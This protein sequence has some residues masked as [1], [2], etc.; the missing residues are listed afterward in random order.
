MAE[1]VTRRQ[2]LRRAVGTTAALG[3]LAVEPKLGAQE[4]PNVLFILADDLGYGD[5]S[6]YGRPDYETPALDRLAAQGMRF[7]SAYSAGAVCTP[8]RCALITGRYPQRLAV[9]L[10]EPLSVSSPEVGIPAGHPTLSSLM[11]EAGY[12]TALIGK[13]HL[14]WRPEFHPNRHGYDQFFGCL[15]GAVDYFTHLAPDA[16][17]AAGEEAPPDLWENTERV[18]REGYLTELFTDRAV[19]YVARARDKP[20]FLSLHYTAPHSPWEGPADAHVA[21][22]EHGIGPML[23]GGSLRA[24]ATMM[25]SLDAGIARVLDALERA[26]AGRVAR[27]TLVIFTSDNGG[28]RF[29]FNW[30]FSFAKGSLFEGGLRVPAI[31]RWPG[32]VPMNR[33]TDQAAIT[34][35]WSATILAAAGATPAAAD[36]PLDGE[37]LLPVCTGERAPYDRTLFWRTRTQAAA[38]VGNWKYVSAGGAEH[39]YD[40]G[41]DLG[42][43]VDLRMRRSDVLDR[44]R[45]QHRAW[46]EQMLPRPTPA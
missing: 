21:H 16:A 24:F 36:R 18:V 19:E 33:T 20:F 44:L 15:S 4:R 26:R 43:K 8:T 7:T 42:E 25:Q 1:S 3:A 46:N 40:L 38:R 14:G 45:T 6:C 22:D 2:F 35:D 23:E 12:E 10:Q 27:N 30:P 11:R 32:V 17:A 31:V 34:M 5:L 29:S 41:V 28:E 39:L 9:G 13:W 37:D